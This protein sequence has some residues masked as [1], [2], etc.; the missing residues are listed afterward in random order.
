MIYCGSHFISEP[1]A[2]SVVDI[3]Y[4]V[5]VFTSF[6]VCSVYAIRVHEMYERGN[7]YAKYQQELEVKEWKKL[8]DDIPEPV[9]FTYRNEIHFFNK[10]MLKLCNLQRKG[11]SEIQSFENICDEVK[12]QLACLKQKV[13]KK[14]LR[15][16]MSVRRFSTEL[17]DE[18][19]FV[20][21]KPN[22]GKRTLWT[23]KCVQTET[24]GSAEENGIVEYIF[25]NVTALKTLEKNKA[26][27]K[28]L[29]LLLAT[30]SHDIKTPL[31]IMLGVL[32]SMEGEKDPDKLKEF[33]GIS[34]NCGEKML[35]YIKG[36]SFISR[37]IF[38]QVKL[39]ERKQY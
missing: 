25:H 3:L 30:A 9:L 12:T 5:V 7:F 34:R 18:S 2:G 26:K 1:L 16:I 35:H 22:N 24:G 27:E 6:S 20:Y 28:F 32:D 31:N 4:Y 8:L 14:S 19:L 15:E 21:K 36:L 17:T 29:Y 38:M 37:E 33:V 11:S 13:T 23:I 10:S 39:K